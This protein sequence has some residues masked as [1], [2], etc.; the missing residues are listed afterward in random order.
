V[1]DPASPFS[2]RFW[3]SA[4]EG[5][6]LRVGVIVDGRGTDRVAASIVRD[7][8]E[9][10][11]VSLE[12]VLVDDGGAPEPD[13]AFARFRA[14]GGVAFAAYA[15]V[16]RRRARVADDPRGADDAM[17]VLAGVPSIAVASDHH[18]VLQLDAGQIDR[19][20][21]A[22]LDV[23]LQLG[24]HRLR[25]LVLDAA[26]CGVWA[27]RPGDGDRWRG[28]PAGFWEHLDRS[29][30]CSMTLSR[31][32][33][34]DDRDP[35][36]GAGLVLDR[37][38]FS[39]DPSSLARTRRT[40]SYG[41]THLVVRNL[42]LLHER[43]WDWLLA[44]R[45]DRSASPPGAGGSRARGTPPR[46]VA[47]AASDVVRWFVPLAARRV[48][49]R[50]IR[51]ATRSPAVLHWRIAIRAG[52]AHS[53]LDQPD[54]LAGFRWIEAPRGHFWAD[55]FLAEHDGQRWLFVED[56]DYAR[57]A[58]CIGCAEIAPDGEPGP[59]RE[60]L[61]SD[62][63]LS[64]PFFVA[65]DDGEP[66]LIPESSADGAV[67]LFGTSSFPLGWSPIAD[68]LPEAAVDTT[69]WRGDDRWWLFT[70]VA[71]P[72]GRAP[73]LLLYHAAAL[74]G[75][76][77]PHPLNPVSQDVRTARGAGSI[78]RHDGRLMRPSQDGGR[79]YGY[80]LAFN[81]IEVLTPTEYR[82]RTVAL[83]TPDRVPGLLGLHTYNRLGDLEVIDGKVARARRSVV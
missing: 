45:P 41:S 67:R 30:V 48:A 29:P 51:T 73:M 52:H 15:V 18:G 43:G 57:D 79:A 72:R 70:T 74:E 69:V 11:F 56:Y 10:G 59:M 55:P 2:A 58:A 36:T 33:D 13:S 16:D 23:L 25:G 26:T 3:T 21:A 32:A 1:T 54:D 27:V 22:H 31:L 34:A 6:P 17:A 65:D 77:T 78:F 60:A 40:A 46:E 5:P 68:L 61:R 75:P 24:S 81:E 44:H 28:G 50:S 53:L 64:Y 66:R 80:A 14:E 47:P 35:A 9:A 7:L 71:E 63:H 8:V 19:V 38:T 83:V 42:R 76:W 4:G 37:A 49:A 12:L 39:T 62:G 20:R 82:E